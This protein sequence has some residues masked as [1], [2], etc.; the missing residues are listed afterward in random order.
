[1]EENVLSDESRYHNFLSTYR[2]KV[3]LNFVEGL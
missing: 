1:M 2:E 3:L